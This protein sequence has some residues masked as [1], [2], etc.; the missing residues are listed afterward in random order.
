M[1]NDLPS[2]TKP[3]AKRGG[4]FKFLLISLAP[5]PV[6][7]LGVP[8]PSLQSSNAGFALKLLG[9]LSFAACVYGS[10]GMCGG[11]DAKS[12]PSSWFTGIVLGIVL[13]VVEGF[14]VLFVGC[15]ATFGH[16]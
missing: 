5:I 2:D 8:F 14:I 6:G 9:L 10:I 4:K 11:Y 13:F 3:P 12:R 15:V 16:L 7:L 1:N